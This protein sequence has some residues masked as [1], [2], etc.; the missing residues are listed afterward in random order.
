MHSFEDLRRKKDYKKLAEFG[1]TPEAIDRTVQCLMGYFW[2][3][4]G[5]Q[6]VMIWRRPTVP[7]FDFLSFPLFVFYVFVPLAFVLY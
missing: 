4:F 3:R 7:R 1:D 6:D 2:A 5:H